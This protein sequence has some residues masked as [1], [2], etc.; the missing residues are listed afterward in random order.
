MESPRFRILA[1]TTVAK[2]TIESM[3]IHAGQTRKTRQKDRYRTKKA[4]DLRIDPADLSN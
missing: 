3:G 2:E 1:T 4:Q